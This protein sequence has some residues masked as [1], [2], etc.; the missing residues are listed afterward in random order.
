MPPP[1]APRKGI[2]CAGRQGDP[3]VAPI[4]L[5]GGVNNGFRKN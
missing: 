1:K 3:V 4:A 5:D 2:E